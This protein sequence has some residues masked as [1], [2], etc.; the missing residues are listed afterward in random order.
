MEEET[1][2]KPTSTI[3]K[4]TCQTVTKDA[5]GNELVKL[6]ASYDQTLDEDRRFAAATP[7]GNAEF[8]ISNPNLRGWYEPGK[9]YYLTVTEA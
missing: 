8:Y 4:F 3:C 1:P 9:A 5:S 7:S 2:T 6:A